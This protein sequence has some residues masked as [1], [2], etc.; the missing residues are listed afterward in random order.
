M[1]PAG[2]AL[3]RP[4]PG[5]C[6]ALRGAGIALRRAKGKTT[7]RRWKAIFLPEHY[8]P[9]FK[10]LSATP[11]LPDNKPAHART[12]DRALTNSQLR[13]RAAFSHALGQAD[14]KHLYQT[15]RRGLWD[16]CPFPHSPTAPR[17]AQGE[18]TLAPV[19]VV[20]KLSPTALGADLTM[21]P[22]P[23]Q[24]LGAR[25]THGTST[26]PGPNTLL[27]TR[28]M[29][30]GWES[31]C[32]KQ[33]QLPWWKMWLLRPPPL[34]FKDTSVLDNPQASPQ[35]L[36]GKVDLQ[37]Q[38]NTATCPRQRWSPLAMLSIS[39][40]PDDVMCMRKTGPLCKLPCWQ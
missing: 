12:T 17:P 27:C 15:A 35:G 14:T 28:G 34:P 22:R 11:T 16:D 2:P 1:L 40:N 25:T 36:G 38:G 39:C 6:Q 37:P 19:P 24:L 26:G 23:V 31:C 21:H 3:G 30:C 4:S 5:H 8:H 20:Q 29:L 13:F 10:V 7:S 32:R 18:Q 33:P 9:D